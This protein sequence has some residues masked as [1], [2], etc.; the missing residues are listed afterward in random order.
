[1]R[2]ETIKHFKQPIKHLK[3]ENKIIKN[4]LLLLPTATVYGRLPKGL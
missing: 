4:C 3:H 1:V 2:G